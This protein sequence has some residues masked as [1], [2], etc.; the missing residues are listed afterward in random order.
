MAEET[1]KRKIRKDHKYR[2]T[3][4]ELRQQINAALM[5]TSDGLEINIPGE[6]PMPYIMGDVENLTIILTGVLTEGL[7]DSEDSPASDAVSS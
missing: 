5:W 4:D 1:K 6:K 7:P 2:F 3:K